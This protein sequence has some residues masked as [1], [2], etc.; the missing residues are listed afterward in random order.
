M[1]QSKGPML[2][3]LNS[4]GSNTRANIPTPKNTKVHRYGYIISC[5]HQVGDL[6]PRGKLNAFVG[7]VHS[8]TLGP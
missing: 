4:R 2:R 3:F 5:T 1:L 7:G 8:V 6:L